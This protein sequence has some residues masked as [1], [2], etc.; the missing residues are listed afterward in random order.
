MNNISNAAEQISLFCRMNL[1]TK[2]ELPIRS[3]EMGLLIYLAKSDEEKTPLGAARFFKVTKAMAAKMVSSLVDK[4]YIVKRQS[5]EDKRSFLLEPTT[6]GILLVEETYLE[7][8][9]VITLLKEKMGDRD[10]E[11]FLTMLEK[12]NRIMLEEKENA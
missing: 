8:F 2:K 1:N 7:Y 5:S 12:A 9:K 6:I 10:F 4:G 3:S 11:T